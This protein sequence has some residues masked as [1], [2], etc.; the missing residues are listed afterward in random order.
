MRTRRKVFCV[1]VPKQQTSD[2]NHAARVGSVRLTDWE[3]D[4]PGTVSFLSSCTFPMLEGRPA[5]TAN[6]AAVIR[7]YWH[8]GPTRHVRIMSERLM[9]MAILYGN[10][11]SFPHKLCHHFKNTVAVQ[12]SL[13]RLLTS[14]QDQGRQNRT[15]RRRKNHS[16]SLTSPSPPLQRGQLD[17]RSRATR[18]KIKAR[19][20]CYGSVIARTE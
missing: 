1:G 3:A 15:R 8:P 14:R 7:L 18:I 5:T 16:A 19:S 20:H 12:D 11:I 17:P 10:D 9:M 13:H 6:S 2:L 4:E